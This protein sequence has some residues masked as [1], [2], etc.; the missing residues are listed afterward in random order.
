MAEKGHERTAAERVAALRVGRPEL[1]AVLDQLDVM[2]GGD[3][4][5][6]GQH[7]VELLEHLEV[8]PALAPTSGGR[9]AGR[10]VAVRLDNEAMR[11]LLGLRDEQRI[12]RMYAERDPDVVCVLLEGPEPVTGWGWSSVGSWNA[13]KSLDAELAFRG[14]VQA[15]VI[16]LTT[17]AWWNGGGRG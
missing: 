1:G 15:P 12:V 16:S 2:L 14:S 8:L 4:F 5:Q 9:A 6:E 13:G 11:R 10:R 7:A 17:L 3:P